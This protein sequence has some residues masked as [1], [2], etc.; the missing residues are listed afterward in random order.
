VQAR[1][2]ERVRDYAFTYLWTDS[3]QICSEHTTNHNK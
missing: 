2:C 3:L 1:I